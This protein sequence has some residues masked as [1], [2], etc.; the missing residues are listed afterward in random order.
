MT[1]RTTAD[2]WLEVLNPIAP[3]LEA[4]PSTGI[5]LENL[6]NRW[7]LITGHEIE[8]HNDGKSFLVRM[9]LQAP[10]SK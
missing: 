5:G 2:G 9:P 6:K 1:I 4:E 3:K 7:R 10:T 8:V